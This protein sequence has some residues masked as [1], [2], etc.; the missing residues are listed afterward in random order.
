MAGHGDSRT[1]AIAVPVAG[2]GMAGTVHAA[3]NVAGTVGDDAFAA[4]VMLRY[5]I[6][7]LLNAY[8]KP[9]AW[10]N[11]VRIECN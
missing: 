10:R 4:V 11:P 7:G 8:P 2:T 6:R 1:D 5:S 3:G 9:L